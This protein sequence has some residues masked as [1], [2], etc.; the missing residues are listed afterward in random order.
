MRGGSDDDWHVNGNIGADLVYGGDGHDTLF[1]G[2]GNDQVFGEAGND[3]VSGDFDNDTLRGGTGNDWLFGSHGD[4][5]ILGEDGDDTMDGWGGVDSLTGGNGN[6]RLFGDFANDTLSGDHGADTLFGGLGD[7]LLF[8]VS[9][10]QD[11]GE[12]DVFAFGVG[13]GVDVVIGFNPFVDWIAL[14]AN[15]NGTGIDTPADALAAVFV[16]GG[17]QTPTI[18]DLGSGNT[19]IFLDMPIN[20]FGLESFRIFDPALV[21]FA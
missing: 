5:Q 8:G 13:S 20:A 21:S 16:P 2:Q 12:I 7:D 1:G 6:D 17:V 18:L 15:V 19:V 3:S 4:D 14:S 10:V 9:A 11:S